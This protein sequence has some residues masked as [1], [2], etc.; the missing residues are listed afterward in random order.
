MLGG[1]R[2]LHLLLF[3][4]GGTCFSNVHVLLQ[5][6]RVLFYALSQHGPILLQFLL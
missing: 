3:A 5:K 6:R 4:S 1:G 2:L